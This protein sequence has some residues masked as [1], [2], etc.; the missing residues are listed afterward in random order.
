LVT[1]GQIFGVITFLSAGR[2]FDA[3]DLG[4]AEEVA[5][6]AALA[7]ENARLFRDLERREDEQRALREA[8]QKARR[9]AEEANR[10]KSQFLATMSHELRTPLNAISGHIQ[11]IS[12]GLHGPV[13]E[14]QRAAL[15][16]V[17]RAQ[18]RLLALINDILNFA[19]LESGRVEYDIQPTPAADPIA[20]VVAL[21]DPQLISLG[22][23]LDLRLPAGS[24]SVLVRADREKLVQILLNL[25]SNATK[26]T[27]AGGGVTLELIV[28]DRDAT[29]VSIRVADTG[30]GIAPDKLQSIFEPFVQLGRSLARTAEGTGLGLAI[31]RDLARAMGGDLSVEST[32][33][34]G[35]AFTVTLQR[36]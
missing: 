21:M 24:G 10:S 34:V 4:L 16:R 22:L 3:S 18:E 7:L 33:G 26:F 5:R 25:L 28:G 29:T 8:E 36:A 15:A 20:E 32:P 13:T 23:S 30:V 9:E 14:P 6:R 17:S 31:S 11:L 2:R 35:S 19:R 27:P 12:L 1:R